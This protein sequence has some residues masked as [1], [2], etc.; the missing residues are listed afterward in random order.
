MKS[1]D[2]TFQ[3]TEYICLHIYLPPHSSICLSLKLETPFAPAAIATA[4]A[5][6]Q[7][8]VLSCDQK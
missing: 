1:V 8:N 7:N 5:T 4:M 2:M 6:D 3:S